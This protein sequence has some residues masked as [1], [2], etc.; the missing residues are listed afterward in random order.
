MGVV[1]KRLKKVKA[2][3]GLLQWESWVMSVVHVTTLVE[4]ESVVDGPAFYIQEE[5]ER[6]CLRLVFP[7]NHD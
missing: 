5:E 6:M 2:W 4:E 3:K 7:N 1:G